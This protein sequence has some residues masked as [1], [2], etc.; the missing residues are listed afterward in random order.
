MTADAKHDGFD[1]ALRWVLSAEG[2]YVAAKDDRGGATHY[3]ISLR[4][5][6]SLPD[7]DSDGYGDGDLNR[8]GRVDADDVRW[9]T[10]EA[11]GD[12]Y[13]TEFWRPAR[14]AELP[15]WCALS[16]FDASVHHGQGWAV[17]LMQRALRVADDGI[18]GPNT[19]RAA[20]RSKAAT[21]V[22]DALSF[23]CVR[24]AEIVRADASQRAWERG[25]Y[26]RLFNLQ[27]FILEEV[28]HV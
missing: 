28:A 13:R 16:L 27:A 10:I 5:L 25:W 1:Q 3:G 15:P 2:G 22:P 12:I 6:Q 23:R 9:L 18:I 17:R 20:S 24:M 7:R 26:R 4:F 11:V 8:D 14:C 19:L 21:F